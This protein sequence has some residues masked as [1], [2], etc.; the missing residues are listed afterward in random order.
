MNAE[1]HITREDA[2][3]G[4][5]ARRAGALLFPFMERRVQFDL[6]KSNS[7][8]LTPLKGRPVEVIFI[9]I[10]AGGPENDYTGI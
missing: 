1:S 10:F 8:V 6:Q 4:L 5:L 3:S 9:S 7:R 2:I